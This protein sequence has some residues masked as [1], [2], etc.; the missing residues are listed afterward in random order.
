MKGM[1]R[2]LLRRSLEDAV[3]EAEYIEEEYKINI[4]ANSVMQMGLLLY[5]YRVNTAQTNL[6]NEDILKGIQ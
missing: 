3:K 4:P 1:Y 5:K 6:P 2:D